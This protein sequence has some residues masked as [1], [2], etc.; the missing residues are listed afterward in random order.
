MLMAV[1]LEERL[2][3]MLLAGGEL[4]MFGIWG[5]DLTNIARIS[6]GGSDVVVIAVV[7]RQCSCP[8]EAICFSWNRGQELSQSFGSCPMIRSTRWP[9]AEPTASFHV[10]LGLTGASS[11]LFAKPALAL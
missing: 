3:L 7:Y 8:G 6:H 1:T 2:A 5:M 9:V 11:C 4:R 10:T